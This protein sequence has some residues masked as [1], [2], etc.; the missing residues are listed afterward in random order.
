MVAELVKRFLHRILLPVSFLAAALIRPSFLS[1]I[2]AV[3]A[4]AGPV[5]PSIKAQRNG[6][7]IPSMLR[8]VNTE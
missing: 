2:Y 8:Y 7:R 5:F 1:L 3:L 4:L 6:G